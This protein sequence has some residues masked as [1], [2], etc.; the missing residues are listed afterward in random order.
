MTVTA[1]TA[2]KMFN[3]YGKLTRDGAWTKIYA[4]RSMEFK[5]TKRDVKRGKR[6]EGD[7][8]PAA[9]GVLNNSP[10]GAYA[11]SV[12][13]GRSRAALIN[14]TERVILKFYIGPS[15]RAAIEAFDTFNDW[16]ELGEFVLSPVPPSL[17]AG[18]RSPGL[19][20]YPAGVCRPR[21]GRRVVIRVD[22]YLK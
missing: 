16:P 19:L 22:S 1:T 8:C 4:D 20:K 11:D 9:N 7:I 2:R 3:K 13:I 5:I 14:W 10:L 21:R 17:R 15:L 18:Y 12:E 6:L